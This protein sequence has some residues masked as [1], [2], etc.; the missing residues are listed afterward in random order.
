MGACIRTKY[1]GSQVVTTL[2]QAYQL[3]KL[4]LASILGK[5]RSFCMPYT[6]SLL[7]TVELDQKITELIGNLYIAIQEVI[8]AETHSFLLFIR[9]FLSTT[10]GPEVYIGKLG[11]HLLQ[12]SSLLINFIIDPHHKIGLKRVRSLKCIAVIENNRA[13]RKGWCIRSEEFCLYQNNRIIH[14]DTTVSVISVISIRTV[15]QNNIGL[16]V[17]YLPDHFF[18]V[19]KGWHQFTIMDIKYVCCDSQYIG[20]ILDLLHSPQNEFTSRHPKVTDISVGH[21]DAFECMSLGSPHGSNSSRGDFAIIRMGAK[22]DNSK[23]PI[24]GLTRVCLFCQHQKAEDKSNEIEK[25]C[26]GHGINIGLINF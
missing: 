10:I 25:A 4:V 16:P 14:Q 11:G 17:P 5:F 13:S 6:T 3:Y 18:P 1:R 23:S 26:A 9:N 22:S 15:H 12:S 8:Q 2:Y 21:G 20:S 7:F 24:F 19:F